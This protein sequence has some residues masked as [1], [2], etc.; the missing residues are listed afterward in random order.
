MHIR[1]PQPDLA[2]LLQGAQGIVERRST[3]R[4][5][6]CVLLEAER[7]ELRLT[8][9]D[10]DVGARLRCDAEVKEAGAICLPARKIHEIVRLL[11]VESVEI[12]VREGNRVELRCGASVFRIAGLP[13]DEFPS[14]P[15]VGEAASVKLPRQA[16]KEMI[17]RVGFSITNDDSRYALNGCLLTV[18]KGTLRMVA[19]DGHR[20]AFV[21]REL[22]GAEGPAKPIEVIV[23]KKTMGE[24]ARL[25]AE[26]KAENIEVTQK[27]NQIMFRCGS[28]ELIS[29]LLEG[30]FPNYERVIPKENTNV[31][32]VE[33]AR[34]GDAVRRVS[35][36]ASEHTR[37][38][39]LALTPGKVEVSASSPE[40]GDAREVLEIPYSG[41]GVHIGFNARYI[42]DFIAAA[43]TEQVSVALRDKDT[44]GLLRPVGRAGEDYR[45]VVMPMRL[46]E[47]EEAP[48]KEG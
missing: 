16:F 44:Q 36:L 39:R 26:E 17:E 3:M 40:Q 10:L 8:A 35:L 30:Q 28:R 19:S 31:F 5:L 18:G 47:A 46:E 32:E 22:E 37:T 21:A 29:R 45:Y 14:L 4:I 2:R 48:G 15:Q 24:L 42:L 6:E 25:C 33:A 13:R 12:R 20:L 9:T 27:D 11:P 23:P 7:G 38:V 1:I 41:G 43:G 34:L